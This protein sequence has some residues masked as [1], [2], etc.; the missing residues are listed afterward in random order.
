MDVSAGLALYD[1]N[2]AVTTSAMQ[3]GP[4]ISRLAQMMTRDRSITWPVDAVDPMCRASKTCKSYLIA[5]PYRTVQPW[6]FTAENETMD[7]FRLYNTP[8]YQVDMWDV[9]REWDLSFN[10]TSECSL[11]GGFDAAWDYSLEICMKEYAK[12]VLVAGWKSCQSGYS[13]TTYQCLDPGSLPS[14]KQGW[15]TYLHFYRRN[16]TVVFSRT[17]FT[18]LDATD[19]SPPQSQNISAASLFQSVNAILYRPNAPANNF[20]YDRN[21]QP[22]VL[23][24]IIGSD[25][26]RSLNV[27]MNGLAIG[28]D[29]LRNI[30]I[31][32]V[33]LFQATVI[34]LNYNIP[35]RIEN[36]TTPLVNL[37]Q[38]NYVRGSYCIVRTQAVPG[39]ET[40]IGY[41]CVAGFVLLFVGI[42][43][44]VAFQWPEAGTS[45]FPLLDYEYKTVLAEGRHEASL[46]QKFVASQRKYDNSAILDEIAD[47]RVGL[48]SV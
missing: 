36:G 1:P 39:L 43:K 16:A 35:F 2:L 29:W 7:G 32:P 34:A 33:Y 24:Q 48:R 17:D 42:A 12:D 45:E 21:S 4:Y 47:L 31:L 27:R 3:T 11:Y 14:G 44:L 6:P 23:T 38:E 30:L 9:E 8:F 19:F 26:W 40:V 15:T 18:I 28:R 10:E 25:L 5:G 37:P 41:A 46:R 20:Q 22:Y 13:N